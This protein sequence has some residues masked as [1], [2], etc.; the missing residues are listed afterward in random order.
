MGPHRVACAAAA[1]IGVRL[2]TPYAFAAANLVV[3]GASR[4]SPDGMPTCWEKSGW[5]D[6]EFTFAV[7]VSRAQRQQGHVRH[8]VTRRADG[9]RKA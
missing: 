4:P 9:D 3:N 8:A 7:T 2:P 1:V 6:N 5:G